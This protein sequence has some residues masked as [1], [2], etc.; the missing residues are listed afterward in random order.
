MI[1]RT[2]HKICGMLRTLPQSAIT[3]VFTLA[4]ASGL[5]MAQSHAPG[6]HTPSQSGFLGSDPTPPDALPWKLLAQVET[7][8]RANNTYGPR[9]GKDVKKLDQQKVKLFGFMMPLDAAEN[10]RRFLL[11]PSPNA[12]YFC[13]PGG[14]ESLVEVIVTKPVKFTYQPIALTGRLNV[15]EDDV[16]Y[17]RLTDAIAVAN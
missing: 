13:A 5:A 7:L 16:V 1:K 15:L 2:R 10:Q 11:S 8:K 3:F 14:P 6:F 9:F 4:I 17:Y 12:C